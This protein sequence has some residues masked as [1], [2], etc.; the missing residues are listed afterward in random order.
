MKTHYDKVAIAL[1]WLMAACIVLM[2]FLGLTMEDYT[3][4]EARFRAVNFHKA[5]G[6]TLL[7]LAVLRLLWRLGHRPPPLPEHMN[8]LERLAANASHYLL[9]FFMIAI[10][11][12]GWL[13][14]SAYAKY[15]I[16]F[17]GLFQVPY[18]PLT[19]NRDVGA[20]FAEAHEWLAYALIALLVA[21]IAAALKHHFYDRDE[22]LM[23]MIPIL[24]RRG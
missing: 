4:L 24:K 1:H 2:L 5:L 14:S 16:S 10:P 19:P 22:V 13:F 8:R 18:L 9:Y 6:I 17:F 23:H 21:H 20:F 7:A 12:S 3:P 11:L 15:P